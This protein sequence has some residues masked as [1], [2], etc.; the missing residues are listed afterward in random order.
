MYVILTFTSVSHYEV[1]TI[2]FYINIS[3]IKWLFIF[4]QK[5]LHELMF[6]EP[7]P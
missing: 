7:S 1:I 4:V 3:N 5:N 6:A 2:I